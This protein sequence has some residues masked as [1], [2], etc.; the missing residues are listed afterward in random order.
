MHAFHTRAC[1]HAVPS[2]SVSS[3]LVGPAC[4]ALHQFWIQDNTACE[5]TLCS[6]RKG[7]NDFN[8]HSSSG[9]RSSSRSFVEEPL[10]GGGLSPGVR[11]QVVPGRT[12]TSCITVSYVLRGKI[13]IRDT[14]STR[15]KGIVRGLQDAS[16]QRTSYTSQIFPHPS[17]MTRITVQVLKW[18]HVLNRQVLWSGRRRHRLEQTIELRRDPQLVQDAVHL[19]RPASNG[20]REAVTAVHGHL[21]SIQLE[22]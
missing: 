22:H 5:S 3:C 13:R 7:R 18:H 10:L 1:Y 16:T 2:R 11:D 21:P 14:I 4:L 12:N 9:Q 8:R 20:D 17:C 19:R 15:S 6:S